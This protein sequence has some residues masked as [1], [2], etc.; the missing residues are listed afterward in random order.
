MEH[1]STLTIGALQQVNYVTITEIPKM[2]FYKIHLF[3]YHKCLHFRM[4]SQPPDS[5]NMSYFTGFLMV[6]R[7]TYPPMVQEGLLAHQ[8]NP[9][10]TPQDVKSNAG[11]HC[12]QLNMGL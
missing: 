12:F 7:K 4:T 6:F 8:S 11:L 2:H 9:Y 5:A 10:Q 3:S 1:V